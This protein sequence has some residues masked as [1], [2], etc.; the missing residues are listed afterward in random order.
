LDTR[1]SDGC[2]AL[3]INEMPVRE[4]HIAALLD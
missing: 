1:K 3:N 2:S 4:Y